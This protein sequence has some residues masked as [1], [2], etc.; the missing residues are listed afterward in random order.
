M[1]IT[2]SKPAVIAAAGAAAV[3]A[4]AIGIAVS[5]SAS[6]AS[7]TPAASSSATASQAPGWGPGHGPGRGG[8]GFA[9]RRFGGPGFG[10]PGGPGGLLLHGEQVV[11]QGTKV[12]T[13]DEQVG[14]ITSVTAA[15]LTVKSSD[16]YTATYTLAATTMVG[17]NG[18]QA[19]ATDLKVGDQVRVEGTKV[20]ATVTASR[21]MDGIAPRPAFQPGPA[22]GLAGTPVAARSRP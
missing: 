14:K 9:G 15:T 7:S 4:A 19:K 8:P 17:K 21:V 12:V 16:G 20:G 22:Y 6:A 18:A 5:T 11:Q 1:R 3:V 10:G 13:V 2:G